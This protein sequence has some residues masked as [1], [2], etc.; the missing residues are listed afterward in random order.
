MN[1]IDIKIREMRVEE[2]GKP[3][4][5]GEIPGARNL[6]R[7]VLKEEQVKERKKLVLCNI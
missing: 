6:R 3:K 4:N 1:F 2:K 7:L 5:T